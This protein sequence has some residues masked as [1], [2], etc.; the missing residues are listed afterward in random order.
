[1]NQ[2][3]LFEALSSLGPEE[4]QQLQDDITT[5][6]F[7][8][9]SHLMETVANQPAESPAGTLAP[10][11]FHL[12]CD[13]PRREMWAIT[14]EALLREGQAAAF[15]VAGGQGSRLGFEG[16]KGA[17]DIGL[18]SGKSIFHLQAERLLHLERRHGRAIPWCIMTSPLNHADT[19]AHFEQHAYFGL[20]KEFVRF[21]PQGMICALDTDGRAL[22]E[23]PSRLALVPDG[24]GGCFRALS[25]S[26]TLDW[27]A[28]L[29]VRFV[30]LYGVDNILSRV[31][32]PLFLGALA[33][34][35]QMPS[36]SKVVHKRAAT[37]KVGIFALRD[38]KPGVIEYSDLPDTLRDL[39]T[40]DG[41]LAYDG[42]NIATHLFRLDALRKLQDQ[43]LPWH[44]A[45]KKV[46]FC[47]AKG[48]QQQPTT[49]NAWKF[50]QFLFDAFPI[51]GAM[52]PVGVQRSEEFAPVKNAS[53]D[54]SPESARQMLGTLHREW[55][56]L[57]GA[58][59]RSDKLY[60]ISPLLSYAGE[61][62][63]AEL[64]IAEIGKGILEFDA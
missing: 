38:G 3:Y 40:P 17:Y 32:D 54:D 7:T 1:M 58:P 11:P 5:Q 64:F 39:R 42:G 51:L 34:T 14:G 26:G 19:V 2:Q 47:D 44:A 63:S 18:P 49:P 28:G 61:G 10:M 60:E 35:A 57:A 12:A 22:R 33:S 8:L 36:A 50:E 29:G 21:F 56:A 27:L 59:V 45:F 6:D 30:F 46:A 55:L 24:N 41:A 23:T 16:P 15:L 13:D 20:Q 9:L 37:E 43:P 25:Q 48:V 53:G 52:L 31:C 62:L 4:R